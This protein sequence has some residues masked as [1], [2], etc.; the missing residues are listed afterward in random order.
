[1]LRHRPFD[2]PPPLEDVDQGRPSPSVFRFVILVAIIIAL[3]VASHALKLE[4]SLSREGLRDLVTLFRDWG[5][6]W[7]VFGPASVIV[8]GVLGVILNVPTVLVL[9]V[10]AII[11][12]P[13][14]TITLT[15]IYWVIACYLVYFIGQHFGHEFVAARIK[16]LPPKA[17]RLLTGN[18]FRTVLYMRLMMFA[19]PPVNW[20]L[21]TLKISSRDYVLASFIGG[22]PHIVFWSVLGPRAINRMLS[23]EPGWWHAPEIIVLS[24][25]GIVLTVIARWLLPKT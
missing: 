16:S 3:I 9:I 12:G 15:L 14:T 7:G 24:L 6:S 20:A 1:M 8:L 23:E 13:V 2:D 22:L 19:F 25:F 5:L 11:Y 10:V 21:A 17:A 18:N 4:A